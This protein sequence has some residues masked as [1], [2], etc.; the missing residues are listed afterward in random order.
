MRVNSMTLLILTFLLM[1][2]SARAGDWQA[3]Q[4][5]MGGK[6]SKMKSLEAEI[7]GLIHEK[8]ATEDPEAVRVIVSSMAQKHEELETVA[9]E[10]RKEFLHIRFQHP[11]QGDHSERQYPRYRLKSLTEME[12]EFGIDAKLD[13]VRNKMR[14]VFG[15]HERRID[16]KTDE[17]QGPESSRAPA[18]APSPPEASERIRLSK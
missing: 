15:S 8:K 9:Q 4:S 12:S 14:A 6:Q 18:Q 16:A 3:H 2:A 5:S 1:A 10:Y 11:E 13:R 17:P 7:E